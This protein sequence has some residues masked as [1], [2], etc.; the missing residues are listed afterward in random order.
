[1]I[2]EIIH[3][4][5]SGLITMDVHIIGLIKCPEQW[6]KTELHKGIYLIVKFQNTWDKENIFKAFRKREKNRL[7]SEIKNRMSSDLPI[8]AQDARRQW[9]STF[10]EGK[11]L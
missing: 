7:F 8:A 9:K 2:K 6:V 4:N 11:L 5:Y 3:E 10:E 1:M